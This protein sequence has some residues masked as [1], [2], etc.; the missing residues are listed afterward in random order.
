LSVSRRAF[1]ESWAWRMVMFAKRT[2]ADLSSLSESSRE[3]YETED[4]EGSREVRR[5][6]ARLTLTNIAT[7]S[8][9]ADKDP[10][11]GRVG[12]RAQPAASQPDDLADGNT[13]SRMTSRTTGREAQ[14]QQQR[15]GAKG[16]YNRQSQAAPQRRD[17][18]RSAPTCTYIVHRT[19]ASNRSGRHLPSSIVARQ[20]RLS[21]GG[22]LAGIRQRIVQ[23]INSRTGTH[24][25]PRLKQSSMIARHADSMQ[26]GNSS[27]PAHRVT[28]SGNWRAER[29][30]RYRIDLHIVN[31]A[32]SGLSYTPSDLSAVLQPSPAA[33]SS[34]RCCRD[35][36]PRPSLFIRP[37]PASRQA[38]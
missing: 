27:L 35:S 22:G 21:E 9:F 38:R 20:R 4:K 33:W 12:D 17:N 7:T 14:A 18:A 16:Q 8:V 36:H 26:G 30:R 2:D 13:T 23:R 24:G 19:S 25:A 6:T 37:P 15:N 29:F 5:S 28:L 34:P 10:W 32:S 3:T 11:Q 1:R 31:R